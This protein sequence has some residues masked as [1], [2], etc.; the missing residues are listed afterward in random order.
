MN[1][2][3]SPLHF[4]QDKSRLYIFI[5][6]LLMALGGA[7]YAGYNVT[8]RS[9]WQDT[10][11]IN[12]EDTGKWCSQGKTRHGTMY[13]YTYEVQGVQ[14]SHETCVAGSPGDTPAVRILSYNPKNPSESLSNQVVVFTVLGVVA[15]IVGVTLC[16]GAVFAKSAQPPQAPR[17][18]TSR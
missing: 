10:P 14:Y 15:A 6:G 8:A 17:S 1:N 4:W 12:S 13:R 2:S 11:I 3:S 7:G 9:D 5:F 18:S 16:L